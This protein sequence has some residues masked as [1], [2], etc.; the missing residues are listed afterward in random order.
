MLHYVRLSI[1][2]CGREMGSEEEREKKLDVSEGN[3][4]VEMDPWSHQAGW[5]KQRN[6]FS[7]DINTRNIQ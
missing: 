4:D 6:N 5:N 2:V 3:Y 7:D 1:D